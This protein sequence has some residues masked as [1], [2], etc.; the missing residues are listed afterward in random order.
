MSKV[1]NHKGKSHVA[2]KPY[3]VGKSH[4]TKACFS[5]AT[6]KQIIVSYNE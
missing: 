6:H 4:M 1:S 2:D 5:I 3:M